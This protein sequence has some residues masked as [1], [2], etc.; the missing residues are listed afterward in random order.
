MRR[1]ALLAVLLAACTPKAAITTTGSVPTTPGAS[2]AA[3]TVAS[4]GPTGPTDL[5][6]FPAQPGRKLTY[7]YKDAKDTYEDVY[8]FDKGYTDKMQGYMARVI[9]GTKTNNAE[10]VSLALYREVYFPDVIK[11]EGFYLDRD[12][13]KATTSEETVTVKAGQFKATKVVL[14][15]LTYWLAKPYMVKAMGGP[16]KYQ[17]E[18][19]KLE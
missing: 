10:L 8:T 1:L 17:L 14:N 13:S 5:A 15:E 3:G 16:L 11:N 7:A 9:N 19:T 12:W 2:A 6:A 4:S 18:L